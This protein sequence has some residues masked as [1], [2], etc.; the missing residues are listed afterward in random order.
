MAM[1]KN[2]LDGSP[3]YDHFCFFERGWSGGGEWLV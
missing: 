1:A 3:V 2:S